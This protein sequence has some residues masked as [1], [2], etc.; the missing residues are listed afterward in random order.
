M[1]Y[2]YTIVMSQSYIKQCTFCEAKIK[3][4][5]QSG[6]WLPYQD[7]KLHECKKKNGTNG[8]NGN[9]SDLS[10]EVFLKKLQ[11]IGITID[12]E[13]LRNAKI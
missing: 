5:D 13:K 10:L 7:G 9:N 3:M 12:L 1:P 4:S 11:S 8:H 6:K 2:C